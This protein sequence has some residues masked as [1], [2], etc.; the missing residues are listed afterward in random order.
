[1]QRQNGQR[2]GWPSLFHLPQQEDEGLVA[3]HQAEEP[4][5]HRERGEGGR[6]GEEKQEEEEKE[7][8]QT[9]PNETGRSAVYGQQREHLPLNGTSA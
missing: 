2:Q 4:R 7:V 1:M 6:A 9:K 8:K 5:G 3:T